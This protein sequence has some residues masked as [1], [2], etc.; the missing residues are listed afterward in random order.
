VSTST[1]GSV[2]TEKTIEVS[3]RPRK[4]FAAI[5]SRCR[6]L[7]SGNVFHLTKT[8]DF[9][10]LI[11]VAKNARN[12]ILAVVLRKVFGRPDFQT[13]A[14]ESWFV[15]TRLDTRSADTPLAAQADA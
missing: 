3:A 5:C 12:A 2:Q 6:H 1:P 11:D 4:G 9:G 8:T 10:H 7:M 14:Y 15:C 13:M